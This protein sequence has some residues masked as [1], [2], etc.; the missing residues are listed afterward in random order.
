MSSMVSLFGEHQ[1][2]VQFLV[3]VII[4]SLFCCEYVDQPPYS[5]AITSDDLHDAESDI[6]K[7]EPLPSEEN[8]NDEDDRRF[9]EA[10]A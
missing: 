2:F 3:V 9:L 7:E 4:C 5:A 6:I 8:C 1:R 10:E